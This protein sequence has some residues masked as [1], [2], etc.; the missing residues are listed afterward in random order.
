MQYTLIYDTIPELLIDKVNRLIQNGWEPLG[1]VS[2]GKYNGT[3]S[4]YQA[5]IKKS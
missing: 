2:V 3:P 5:L 1:G 4:F